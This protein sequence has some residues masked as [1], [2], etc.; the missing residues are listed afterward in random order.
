MPSERDRHLLEIIA[1]SYILTWYFSMIAI[2]ISSTMEDNEV[3]PWGSPLSSILSTFNLHSWFGEKTV[4]QEVVKWWRMA[5][6][7]LGHS[8]TRGRYWLQ[9]GS[10][11]LQLHWSVCSTSPSSTVLIK[12]PDAVSLQAINTDLATAKPVAWQCTLPLMHLIPS[13]QKYDILQIR[14]ISHNSKYTSNSLCPLEPS[15]IP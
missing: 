6:I 14:T 2:W 13:L 9:Q 12:R 15:V 10:S 11:V 4:K 5:E 8:G 3:R 7:C 1:H